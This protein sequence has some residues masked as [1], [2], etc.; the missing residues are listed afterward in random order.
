[1]GRGVH[2]ALLGSHRQHKAAP[3]PE[4]RHPPGRGEAWC[5]SSHGEESER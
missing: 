2:R 1:M 3:R 4:A 5:P